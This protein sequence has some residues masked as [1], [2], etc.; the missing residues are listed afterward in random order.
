MCFLDRG[1]GFS[2]N[3]LQACRSA[4]RED[5]QGEPTQ[6]A[7]ASEHSPFRS[8]GAEGGHD[9]HRNHRHRHLRRGVLEAEETAE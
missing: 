7:S 9:R 5:A 4:R 3:F 1:I 6:S 2:S 8:T